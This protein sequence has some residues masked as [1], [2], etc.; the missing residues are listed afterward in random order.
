M[1]APG[2]TDG[3]GCANVRGA[4]WSI[5]WGVSGGETLKWGQEWRQRLRTQSGNRIHLIHRLQ[6]T[7]KALTRAGC[8]GACLQLQR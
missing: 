1:V 3:K 7:I 8:G 5:E 2:T 6:G 4:A